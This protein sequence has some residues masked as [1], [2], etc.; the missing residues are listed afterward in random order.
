VHHAYD[1]ETVAIAAGSI[2]EPRYVSVSIAGEVSGW[3]V[4][5]FAELHDVIVSEFLTDDLVNHSFVGY[6]SNRFDAYLVAQSLKNDDGYLIEPWLARGHQLRGMRISDTENP[7]RFWVFSDAMAMTGF[8][9]SLQSFLDAF[10]PGERKGAIDVLHFDATNALHVAYNHNDT[11]TLQTALDRVDELFADVTGMTAQNTIGKLAIK[12]FQR[13]L[14]EGVLVWPVPQSA[15]D[16]LNIAKRGGYVYC[17]GRYSGPVWKYDI[18]QS[19]A[20]QMRKPL[21]SG[22]CMETF[23]EVPELLGLYHVTLSYPGGA[24]VPFYARSVD[25][26]SIGLT[27]GSAPYETWI[28]SPEVEHLRAFGWQIEIHN[29]WVWS[30]QF[31]MKE[32]VDG[33]QAARIEAGPKT[34][35]GLAIKAVGNNAFGKTFEEFDGLRLVISGDRPS[36]DYF[37]YRDDDPEYKDIW[38]TIEDVKPAD[39]HRPQLGSFITAYGRVQLMD[40]AYMS[41]RAFLY[42][43]TDC[44]V[45]S[46]DVTWLLDIDPAIY[47]H[48]KV[49]EEGAVYSFINK[50]V[51]FSHEAKKNPTAPAIGPVVEYPV[52]AHAKGVHVQE[53][54]LRQFHDWYSGEA[55]PHQDQLQRNNFIA[56][57]AEQDMFVPRGRSGCFVLPDADPTITIPVHVDWDKEQRR[58]EREAK[59]ERLQ[60]IKRWIPAAGLRAPKGQESE[61]R[62]IIPRRF[63]GSAHHYNSGLN[64]MPLDEYA[65][66]LAAEAPWLGVR[67]DSDLAELFASTGWKL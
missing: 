22:R 64:A 44:I 58:L 61:F 54:T 39:Y 52:T 56:T 45:F 7:K 16:G 62:L 32:W 13:N 55:I 38:F 5:T 60:E 25:W 34:P 17:R 3:P 4:H 48:W 37:A 65:S 11:A 33:L 36:A 14:P 27:D 9:G 49:E 31:D 6:N 19:Y 29:G 10:A 63:R 28:V 50:K 57:M 67:D 20:S 47:G 26:G 15:R 21:P 12:A 24:P 8:Q 53:L 2:P 23:H 41:P 46:E 1:L 18:N 51:Y 35:K 42:A 30:D 66:I 59:R 43:D 40:A